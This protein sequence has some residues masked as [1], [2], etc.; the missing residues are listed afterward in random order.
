METAAIVAD[1]SGEGPV[2]TGTDLTDYRQTLWA[3]EVLEVGEMWR[4]RMDPA[5][6]RA[7][8]AAR[9]PHTAQSPLLIKGGCYNASAE[10]LRPAFI[11]FP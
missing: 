5:K 2:M 8:G 10:A 6:R 3:H 4:M 7:G 9:Q 1:S 11:R